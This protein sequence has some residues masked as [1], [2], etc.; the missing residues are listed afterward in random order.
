MASGGRAR[1][2][3][4]PPPPPPPPPVHGGR[5]QSTRDPVTVTT[6]QPR[7]DPVTTPRGRSRLLWWRTVPK[8]ISV[9]LLLLLLLL[10]PRRRRRRR[11]RRST[12]SGRGR[13]YPVGR[14]AAAALGDEGE[15]GAGAAGLA[16]LTGIL[17]EVGDAPHALVVALAAH[18]PH[19]RCQYHHYCCLQCFGMR[20]SAALLHCSIITL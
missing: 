8:L 4:P 15:A 18:L 16:A 9:L 17:G 11:R 3:P 12:Q 13:A 1:E 19:R 6:P 14:G 20:F 7:H 2:K 5:V 10:L